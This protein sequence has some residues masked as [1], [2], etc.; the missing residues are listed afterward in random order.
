MQY[1]MRISFTRA[2]TASPTSAPQSPTS[3][4]R[5]SPSLHRQTSED[6]RLTQSLTMATVGNVR[7]TI[8]GTYSQHAGTATPTPS[9]RLRRTKSVEA[10]MGV[11]IP[12]ARWVG[13]GLNISVRKGLLVR[14][15]R[16][17][18]VYHL[19]G[20]RWPRTRLSRRQI[21]FADQLNFK[22]TLYT[23][24]STLITKHTRKNWMRT[25]THS[26]AEN[27]ASA[28]H[29]VSFQPHS[30][31]LCPSHQVSSPGAHVF[32]SQVCQSPGVFL[33]CPPGG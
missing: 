20:R 18:N 8:S 6:P 23:A 32:F 9:P 29:T 27:G 11:R 22:A 13:K 17:L 33:C 24:H 5:G 30:T 31:F 25:S 26:T 10:R 4:L 19:I 21:K 1:G 7:R 2:H 16:E 12:P 14:W 28:Q 3:S 15:E